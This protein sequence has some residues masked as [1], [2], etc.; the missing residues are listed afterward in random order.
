MKRAI[1]H[2]RIATNIKPTLQ[3]TGVILAIALLP[4]PVEAVAQSD[5]LG[6]VIAWALL[7]SVAAFVIWAWPVKR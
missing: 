3:I 7:A 4:A 1:Y 5:A 6:P 2:R